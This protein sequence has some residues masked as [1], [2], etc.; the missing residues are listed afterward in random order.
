MD[1]RLGRLRIRDLGKLHLGRGRNG[2]PVLVLAFETKNRHGVGYLGRRLSVYETVLL[3]GSVELGVFLEGIQG[4]GRPAHGIRHL[5]LI[6]ALCLMCVVE[7][8]ES[9]GRRVR[10][11]K[12]D[13]GVQVLWDKLMEVRDITWWKVLFLSLGRK[14]GTRLVTD[15]G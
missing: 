2:S 1:D 13:S 4:I 14:C 15:R 12:L 6:L 9:E 11:F 10:A 3:E 5:W 8:E 7:E